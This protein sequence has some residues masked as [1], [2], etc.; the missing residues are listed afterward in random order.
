MQL[1]GGQKQRVAIARAVIKD[2][3]IMLLDEA[4]SALDAAAEREVQTA[5][6]RIMVRGGGEGGRGVE[7]GGA[8]GGGEEGAER[9]RPHHGERGWEGLWRGR[10]GGTTSA[11]D[12]A[13]PHRTMCN[14]IPLPTLTSPPPTPPRP[15]GWPH[16]CGGGTPPLHHPQRRPHRPRLQGGHSGAGERRGRRG[17][18]GGGLQ[19]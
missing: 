19:C 9:T 16:Q 8:Q 2:P 5:L 15:P 11:L 3:K 7:P 12:A 18:R 17:G 4:T 13:A 14:V 6:D 1:S 10:G